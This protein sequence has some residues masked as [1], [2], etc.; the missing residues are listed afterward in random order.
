MVRFFC[1]QKSVLGRVKP[2]NRCKITKNIGYV[3][4]CE[5]CFITYNVYERKRNDVN[6]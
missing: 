1:Y 4:V 6:G 2:K 3:C 5:I